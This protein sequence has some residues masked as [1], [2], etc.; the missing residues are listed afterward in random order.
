MVNKSVN[1]ETKK[2]ANT[3]PGPKTDFLGSGIRKI[4]KLDYMLEN[5]EKYHKFAHDI[6]VQ[7]GSYAFPNELVRFRIEAKPILGKIQKQL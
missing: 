3:S 4:W 2:T 1:F 5:F 6:S 7:N